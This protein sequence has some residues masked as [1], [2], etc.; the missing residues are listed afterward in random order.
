VS[1]NSDVPTL[2]QRREAL[3]LS[4]IDFA[5]LTHLSVSAICRIE[6]GNRGAKGPTLR[7]IAWALDCSE[8]EAAASIEASKRAAAERAAVAS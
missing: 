6:R 7:T 5:E 3:R 8:D 4:Q 1:T 2:R